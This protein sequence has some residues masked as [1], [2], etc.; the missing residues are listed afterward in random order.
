MEENQI[1]WDPQALGQ[2][3]KAILSRGYLKGWFFGGGIGITLKLGIMVSLLLLLAK[4]RCRQSLKFP[5]FT[6]VHNNSYLDGTPLL[7]E[8]Y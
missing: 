7:P 8:V 4:L 3:V 2:K 1:E 5:K 6:K